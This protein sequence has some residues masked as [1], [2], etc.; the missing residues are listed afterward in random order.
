MTTTNS[1]AAQVTRWVLVAFIVILIFVAM[2]LIRDILMLT[3]TAA[4][5]AVLLTTPIRFFVRRGLKRPVA[6]FI[7]LV[8]LIALIIATGAL[9]LPGLWEQ[10][11]ELV[12]RY[13]PDAAAKLQTQLQAPNLVQ[14][15]PFLQGIDPKDLKTITDQLSNQLVGWLGNITPQIFPLVG[16]L[17]STLLSILIVV[18][19]AMYFVADPGMHER[20]MLMLVPIPYRPRA[21]EILARLDRTMRNF[22]QAQIILMLVIGAS[23]G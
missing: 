22:L 15:F 23:T 6:V 16:G 11:R 7:T 8:L 10:F 12:V 4:I 2:W 21:L 18:F 1:S 5:F 13:I 9:L 14:T 17:A 3:L 19:L 20:G